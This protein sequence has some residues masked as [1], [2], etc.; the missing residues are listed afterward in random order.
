[1][2]AL[3]PPRRRE[4]LSSEK[5]AGWGAPQALYVSGRS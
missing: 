4:G 3:V 5:S 1:M 2:T